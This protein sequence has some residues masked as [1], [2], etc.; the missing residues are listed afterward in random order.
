M[1]ED[2]LHVLEWVAQMCSLDK[3]TLW[4]GRWTGKN[5]GILDRYLSEAVTDSNKGQLEVEIRISGM[6]LYILGDRIATL[7]EWF[8]SRITAL[9]MHIDGFESMDE[10]LGSVSPRDY[11]RRGGPDLISFQ[12]L[13]PLRRLLNLHAIRLIVA[14]DRTVDTGNALQTAEYHE[15]P[16]YDMLWA[17][18]LAE[19]LSR[20]VFHPSESGNFPSLRRF[21]AL[22]V[23]IAGVAIEAMADAADFPRETV[24]H[25]VWEVSDG[26]RLN[27]GTARVL[28]DG[29]I[30]NG[31]TFRS[32]TTAERQ[33]LGW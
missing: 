17:F 16:A 26:S 18:L 25:L 2:N 15:H 1:H 27:D 29:V 11:S 28:K 4:T 9:T 7:L 30:E 33:R 12:M 21:E 32:G 3:V 20:L 10:G 5:R 6:S 22:L 31:I 8:P 24:H 13:Y 19:E 23:D 14:E